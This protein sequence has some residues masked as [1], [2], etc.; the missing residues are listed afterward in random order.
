MLYELRTYQ[1]GGGRMAEMEKLMA[2]DCTAVLRRAKVPRPLG[3]WHAVAGPR[4]PAFVWILGW[5]SLEQ[6]NA[7]WAA[8]G[9]DTEWQKLRR[10]A[11]A[12]TELTARVDAQF[13]AAW[14]DPALTAATD[15][16]Q[17]GGVYQLLLLR[18]HTGQGGA[19]RQ[20]FLTTDRPAIEAAG[21]K[22]EAAFDLLSGDDLPVIAVIVH[23]A[24]AGAC[25][26]GMSR[27]DS[28]PSVH[29]ARAAER[30]KL[31]FD[32]LGASDRYLMLSSPPFG[33]T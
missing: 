12:K 3:A 26:A 28:H 27:Y 21:G 30:E 8:F 7:A 29:A 16:A 20:A 14:P 9:A 32:L 25:A 5:S 1:A 17:Q 6:R 11:H 15:L 24:D 2:S 18:V 4:L 13:M 23:W 22:V 31:G 10:E 19:A 33:N